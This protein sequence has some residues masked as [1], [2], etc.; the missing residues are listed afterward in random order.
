MIQ[1]LLFQRVGVVLPSFSI[2][3]IS[4]ESFCHMTCGLASLALLSLLP[5][6]FPIRWMIVGLLRSSQLFF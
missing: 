4:A 3:L 1:I 6:F 5:F 2:I